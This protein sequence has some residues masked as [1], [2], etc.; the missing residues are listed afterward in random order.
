MCGASYR[1]KQELTDHIKSDCIKSIHKG[2][3]PYNCSICDSKFSYRQNLK[4][5]EKAV[6]GIGKSSNGFQCPQCSDCFFQESRLIQHMN[7][8][9]SD[10]LEK[11]LRC[12]SCDV[13]FS[14]DREL[15][16]HMKTK[17]LEL[18]NRTYARISKINHY[19]KKGSTLHKKAFDEDGR[20]NN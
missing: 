4:Y 19:L 20:K 3:R 15:N 5:H 11:K 18:A 13:G 6:H 12:V 7:S 16:E 9:H 17:H 8:F 2:L 14:N 10:G 1:N